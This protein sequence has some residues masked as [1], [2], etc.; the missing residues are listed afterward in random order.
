MARRDDILRSFLQ[1][2]LLKNKY[3][4][5]ENDLPNTVSE[6]INSEHPIV[7]VLGLI[8]DGLEHE[9]PC[10]DA[11]LRNTITQYLNTARFN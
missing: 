5:S 10:T 11:V 1:H 2:E 4:L 9:Q 6:A 3:K 7:H 8:V